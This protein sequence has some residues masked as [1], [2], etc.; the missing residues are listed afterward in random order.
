MI[1]PPMLQPA[2]LRK[3]IKDESSHRPRGPRKTIQLAL[4]VFHRDPRMGEWTHVTPLPIG[5]SGRQYQRLKPGAPAATEA[6]LESSATR[7][8]PQP[9]S[10]TP[11][12]TKLGEVQG[13][14]AIVYGSVSPAG[15]P[16]VKARPIG[17]FL[18]VDRFTR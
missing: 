15:R 9:H 13:Y 1:A 4:L 3:L 10:K 11:S 12:M 16:G 5:S 7:P 6:P 14:Q 8:G 2:V 17:A 18:P